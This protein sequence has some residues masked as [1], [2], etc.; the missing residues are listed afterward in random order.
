MLFDVLKKIIKEIETNYF[1]VVAPKLK[2]SVYC[3]LGT[4]FILG[5][6]ER[7]FLRWS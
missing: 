3:C 4:Q 6:D 2:N 1:E 5:Y 7:W